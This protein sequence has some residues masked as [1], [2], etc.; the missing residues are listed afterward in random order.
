[1]FQ[2]FNDSLNAI[3]SGLGELIFSAILGL[4]QGITEVLPISSTAHLRIFSYFTLSGLDISLRTSNIIQ[5][6]TTIT[7][8]LFFWKDVRVIFEHTK[9]LLTHPDSLGS[10]VDDFKKWA[11]SANPSDKSSVL[12]GQQKSEKL[13]VPNNAPDRNTDL[14][15]SDYVQNTESREQTFDSNSNKNNSNF[16]ED[17]YQIFQKNILLSQLTVGTIPI[18]ILGLLL[19][20]FVSS[21]RDLTEI[22]SYLIAGAMLLIFAEYI[23]KKIQMQKTDS[24]QDD[25]VALSF[26]VKDLREIAKINIGNNREQNENSVKNSEDQ[27]NP[28][29]QNKNQNSE[30]S[31]FYQTNKF[32]FS[33]CLLI[34][35]FQ[36][37][38]VFPGMSRSGSTL[39]GALLLGRNRMDSI[40]FSFLLG[41]PATILA[42]LLDLFEFIWQSFKEGF[43]LLPQANWLQNT[44]ITKSVNLSV[45]SMVLSFLIALVSGYISFRWI[46]GFLGKNSSKGFIIYRII[47]GLFLILVAFFDYIKLVLR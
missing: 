28:K 36:S 35:I 26:E 41:I 11:F 37:L 25:R 14:I 23:Y 5:I 39:A 24:T 29:N 30:E 40:R 32:S 21:N 16:Q 46:L 18:I 38:A 45:T 13:N 42:G 9:W 7:I 6:A 43:V 10:F 34:G 19:K 3:F 8:I 44:S 31:S 15:N 12:I 4:I 2:N 33:D 27:Q 17:R 22:G 47:I 20:N 1:M